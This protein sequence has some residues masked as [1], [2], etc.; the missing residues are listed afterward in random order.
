MKTAEVFCLQTE[1]KL[2][3]CEP[4]CRMQYCMR[5]F[6]K[7]D[8]IF[9]FGF[10][11]CGGPYTQH[12]LFQPTTFMPIQSGVMAPL[13]SLYPNVYTKLSRLGKCIYCPN[14]LYSLLDNSK[15]A[16]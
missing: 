12:G 5:Q 4:V 1:R 7:R 9:S 14:K 6:S 16:P 3:L 11:V 15:T 2:Y 8:A 13:K 10:K